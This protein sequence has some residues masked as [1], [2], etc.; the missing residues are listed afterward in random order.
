MSSKLWVYGAMTI[1]SLIGGYAP[2]LWGASLFS[3]SS[4]IGNTIGA[5]IGIIL[6]YKLSQRFE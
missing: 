6:G 2:V 4:L 1:G 3:F 5:V